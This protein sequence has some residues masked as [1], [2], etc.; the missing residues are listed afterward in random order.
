MLSLLFML[1]C[2]GETP[3][4]NPKNV[5]LKTD[6]HTAAKPTDFDDKS[7]KCC[8][9]PEA[10]ELLSKYLALTKAMAADDD[11]K[12]K[13]AVTELHQFT[14][15]DAF[16]TLS[17]KDD[18][19]ELQEAAQFWTTLERKDIQKDFSEASQNV[20]DFAKAHK[21]DSGTAVITAFC[22]MAPGRWLQTES[23]ISNPYYGSMMLTC[24]VFE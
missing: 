16:S 6:K 18:L 12:T 1:A 14:Q 11:A 9:T 21:S 22:P 23:T 10:T 15:T 4:E 19:K 13:A 20:I 8:D 17:T 2:S 7:F 24:G 3:A 5:V